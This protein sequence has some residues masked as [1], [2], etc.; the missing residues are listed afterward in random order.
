VNKKDIDDRWQLF[1]FFA[2]GVLPLSIIGIPALF[3]DRI[4]EPGFGVWFG[5][6]TIGLGVVG[7]LVM[8]RERLFKLAA[9]ALAVCQPV[10]SIVMIHFAVL[11]TGGVVSSPLSY[12]YIYLPAVVGHVYGR[13]WQLWIASVALALSFVVLLFW[14]QHQLELI[15]HLFGVTPSKIAR[16]GAPM[17]TYLCIFL[18]Q[19]FVTVLTSNS[20]GLAKP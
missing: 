2:G 10:L 4:V 15:R 6:M 12:S 13:R 5:S 17:S 11:T 7:I 1:G 16:V 19:L 8:H 20:D 9:K 3:H 14:Y 18:L